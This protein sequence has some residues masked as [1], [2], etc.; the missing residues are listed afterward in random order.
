MSFTS[1]LLP[2]PETPVTQVSRPTG[3]L[4][5]DVLQIV[6][7]SRPRTV[8]QRPSGALRLGVLHHAAACRARYG[9]GAR[10]PTAESLAHSAGVP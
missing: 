4:R 9:T 6:L 3:K 10:M 7:A 5:V 8:S 1:V 2:E